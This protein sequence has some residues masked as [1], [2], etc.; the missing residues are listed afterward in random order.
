MKH[1]AR[2]TIL[3]PAMTVLEY[4]SR[5]QWTERGSFVSCQLEGLP[6]ASI[7][8]SVASVR[9]TCTNT[10]YIG[11]AIS[12]L[13][14]SSRSKRYDNAHN[15]TSQAHTS[16]TLHLPSHESTSRLRCPYTLPPRLLDSC[17]VMHVAASAVH[18]RRC[19]DTGSVAVEPHVQSSA[20]RS[21]HKRGRGEVHVAGR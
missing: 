18:S 5:A 12:V 9:T 11:Q 14:Y 6:A 10:L 17:S 16:T 15:N 13:Q 19:R 1:G 4:S 2:I 7:H 21:M 20:S 3:T 8:F